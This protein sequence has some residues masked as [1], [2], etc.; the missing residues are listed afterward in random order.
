MYFA[1]REEY[2]ILQIGGGK[3]AHGLVHVSPL[4]CLEEFEVHASA[5]PEWL[6]FQETLSTV[7]QASCTVSFAQC[8]PTVVSCPVHRICQ[9]VKEKRE[10][11]KSRKVVKNARLLTIKSYP[12]KDETGRL[13]T[14]SSCPH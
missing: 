3:S 11:I 1:N 5:T 2:T 8:I 14:E 4:L 9:D 6:S 12:R 10:S 13:L 7:F